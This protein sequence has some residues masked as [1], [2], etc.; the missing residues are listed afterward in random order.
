MQIHINTR[1]NIGETI[2]SCEGKNLITSHSFQWD[3]NTILAPRIRD[4]SGL[5]VDATSHERL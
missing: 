5:N 4:S 1:Q 3:S 2:Q